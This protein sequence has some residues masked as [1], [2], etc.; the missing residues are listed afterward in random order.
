MS[1]GF[2]HSDRV[3]LW[4]CSTRSTP[5]ARVLLPTAPV[6]VDTDEEAAEDGVE[7]ETDDGD[8]LSEFPDETEVRAVLMLTL[9]STDGLLTRFFA[10][11][12]WSLCTL[13]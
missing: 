1:D 7:E 12:T 3:N 2:F 10:S 8:F 9:A 6:D 13:R 11:R 5:T 4:T